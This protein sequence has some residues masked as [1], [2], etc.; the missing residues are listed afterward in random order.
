[1]SHSEQS[2][3]MAGAAQG[4]GCD[5]VLQHSHE[6]PR[7]FCI[8]PNTLCAGLDEHMLLIGSMN[9]AKRI[10]DGLQLKCSPDT[11]MNKRIHK[12]H[13]AQADYTWSSG[14]RVYNL[15]HTAVP[16]L[17]PQMC[18]EDV[19]VLGNHI[20]PSE[21]P[22]P[23]KH[24]K[25]ALPPCPCHAGGACAYR[26]EDTGK[27]KVPSGPCHDSVRHI[28]AKVLMPRGT[29]QERDKFVQDAA[30]DKDV[31]ISRLHFAES[32]LNPN[33]SLKRKNG[34]VPTPSFYPREPPPGVVQLWPAP[35][36]ARAFDNKKRART[37]RSDEDKDHHSNVRNAR[38]R[39]L[40]L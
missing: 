28:W 25:G 31:F 20:P 21:P 12:W 34:S 37:C 40:R 3:S 33:G 5:D 8:C 13:F 4:S 36:P 39:M 6:G 22:K 27:V 18:W 30:G 2:A 35:T 7:R 10:V 17:E 16:T 1:M 32:D 19:H 26:L 9:R 29:A 38:P 24:P 15:A 23:R 11:L 14:R